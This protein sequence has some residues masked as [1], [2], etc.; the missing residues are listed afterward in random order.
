MRLLHTA[1]WHLGKVLKGVARLDEQRA[2]L[3]EMVEVAARE[4]VDAVLVA[5][6]VF[7]SAAPAPDA[8]E[9]A[10]AT[11]LRLRALGIEVVVIAGNHDPAEAFQALRPVFHGAGVIVLGR[12][13]R[14]G[15]GGVVELQV[16]A[17]RQP[18]R[19]ALLPFVTQRGVVKAE[20]LLELDGAQMVQHYR[21]RLRQVLAALTASF[22]ADAVNVVAA[23]AM[24]TGGR[25]GGGE[26]DAHTIFDYAVDA[27]AFPSSASYV[28]LGHLHRQQQIPGPCPIWYPGSPVCI[29]FGEEANR[30]GVLVIDVAPGRPAQVRP[31]ALTRARR[32]RTVTGTV[33]ELR[34]LADGVGDDL[35]RV[36]VTEPARAGMVDDVRAVLPN[37]LDIRVAAP[38]P[39]TMSTSA[40]PAASRLGRSAVEQFALFMAEQNVAD[41]RIEALFAALLDTAASD[42]A[43]DRA[44]SG[45]TLPGRV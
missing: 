17:A 31:V 8:Q 32:L 40:V 25:L 21:D 10:W 37:A 42:G 36:V 44:G 24:V 2:V 14:P 23:H 19:L 43:G 4:Q 22:S 5:G 13:A 1:D 38:D 26:R 16:G 41:P 18:L 12:A 35:L 29:D 28:A 20:Q 33:A 9:L 15:D 39:V 30:P 34:E 7:E 3:D 11:L 45:P 27:T 6:D